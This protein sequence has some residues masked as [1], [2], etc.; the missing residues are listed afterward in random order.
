MEERPSLLDRAARSLA[1][2]PRDTLDLARE[3]L[4]LQGNPVVASKAVLTLL[5]NDQRFVVDTAGRWSL[6]AGGPGPG[7]PL[8]RARFAV[9]DVETT[10]GTRGWGEDRITEV[11]IVHVEDGIIGTSFETLLNPGRPIPPRI[12]GFT[13]ITDRM[14]A[15]APW[16]EA[17]A[18]QVLELLRGRVF[19]AH[20]VRFDWGMIR[21]E[22]LSV[23]EDAPAVERL[24]TV[25]MARRFLPRLRSYGLDRLSA[26]YG[27]RIQARHRAF[28]DAFGTAELLLRLIRE[29]EGAGLTDLDSLW[30]AL[31]PGQRRSG[32]R[33]GRRARRSAPDGQTAESVAPQVP[34]PGVTESGAAAA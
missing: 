18:P 16:F 11:A 2:G 1:A 4:G 34:V 21:R 23:G 31:E 26:H 30:A 5:G 14:V 25:R 28:G 13:G 32:R 22:L 12:Q 20:N 9:V 17:V 27:I 29:A 33:R 10:G 19:V 6:V 15:S 24:C 3:V 7:A 8:S